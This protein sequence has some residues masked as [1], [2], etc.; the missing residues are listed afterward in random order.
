MFLFDWERGWIKAVWLD[1]RRQ[2]KRLRPFGPETRFRRPICLKLG[3]DGALYLLEWGSN[4][5]NNSD[6]A[7]VRLSSA[8]TP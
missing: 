3:P 6:A 2:V 7:L 8:E 4:W 1:E 5:S